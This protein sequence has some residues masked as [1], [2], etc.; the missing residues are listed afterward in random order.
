MIVLLHVIIA[1]TS[2]GITSYAYFRPTHSKLRVSYGLV[3]LTLA[4][5]LYLVWSMPAHMVQ[6]CTSGLIYLGI[7]TVGIVM[8]RARLASQKA[9]NQA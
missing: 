6:A 7:V 9:N 8:A 2:I 1:L 5:G 3:G 4:S